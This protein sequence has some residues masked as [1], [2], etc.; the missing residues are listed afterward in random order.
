MRIHCEHNQS[1]KFQP[2]LP[3]PCDDNFP[4]AFQCF[5]DLLGAARTGSGKTLAFLVPAVEL[6]YKLNFKPRNGRRSTK[7]S[8][9]LKLQYQN[10]SILHSTIL[11]Q[12]NIDLPRIGTLIR[13][14]L[15]G[16]YSP[17]NNIQDL[18]MPDL[19]NQ[20]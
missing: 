4:T 19:T 11:V 13:W 10:I 18:N 5:R 3:L 2:N 20:C 17:D 12:Q 7:T 6:L 16:Q 15:A 14:H 9:W 8:H 1:F